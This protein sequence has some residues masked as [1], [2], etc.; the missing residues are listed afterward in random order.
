MRPEL[1]ELLD[2]NLWS[3][4]EEMAEVVELSGAG[5][6]DSFREFLEE[7]YVRIARET[8]DAGADQNAGTGLGAPAAFRPLVDPGFGVSADEAEERKTLLM[9]ASA[10]DHT[11]AVTGVTEQYS[12]F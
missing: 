4:W 5:A 1:L 12:Q 3:A 10:T 11:F 9:K 2:K 8:C 6:H 7:D